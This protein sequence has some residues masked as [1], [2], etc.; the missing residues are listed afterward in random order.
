MAKR[1]SFTSKAYVDTSAFI[2][3]LDAS[4]HYNEL[5]VRLF[6]NPPRL[7]TTPLVI[8]EGHGWFLKRFNNKRALEFLSFI[9]ELKPLDIVHVGVGE[10]LHTERYVRKFMDQDLTLCDAMGLW[11]MEK[12]R[13]AECWSTDRHLGLTGKTLVI[14]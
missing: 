9:K 4:D 11:L 1:T 12:W 8:A 14:Y 6:A 13:I 2:A 7:L 10:V 3:F 5:F